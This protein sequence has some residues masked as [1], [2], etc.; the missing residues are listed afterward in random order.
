MG[1]LR[2]VGS[3]KL[4]V[5][6]AKEPYKRDYVL[7]KRPIILR[8]LLIVA[9]PYYKWQYLT[10]MTTGSTCSQYLVRQD[11]DTTRAVHTF[12]SLQLHLWGGYDQQTPQK[13]QVSSAE[14]SLFYR[15]RLQKR[16]IILRSLLAEATQYLTWI[17]TGS[18]CSQCLVRQDRYLARVRVVVR[19]I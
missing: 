11:R 9:T 4:Q 2:L 1:W 12:T 3:L 19:Q 18:T 6:F 15:A 10:W 8:R 13:I 7:H 5:S 16:P 14:Y 17:T